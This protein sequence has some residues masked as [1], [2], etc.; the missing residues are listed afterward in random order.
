MAAMK[1]VLI[2]TMELVGNMA[3]TP[4]LSSQ[5][6]ITDHFEFSAHLATLLIEQ[7]WKAPSQKDQA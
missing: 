5:L 4:E 1:A 2:D 3:I 7:G 6:G